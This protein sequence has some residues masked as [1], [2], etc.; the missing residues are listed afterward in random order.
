MNRHAIAIGLGLS[1]LHCNVANESV[2]AA[3]TEDSLLAERSAAESELG[4]EDCGC[5]GD[6]EDRVADVAVSTADRTA[7]EAADA[8]T[9]GPADAPVTVVAFMDYDCPYCVRVNATLSA[10]LAER[11]DVRVV[12]RQH[13]LPFHKRAHGAARA[14]LAAAELGRF[15]DFHQWL[16]ANRDAADFVGEAE[17]LGLDTRAFSAAVD[18]AAIEEQIASD[19]ELAKRLQARG[20]PTLFINGRRAVGALPQERLESLIDEAHPAGR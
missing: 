20:T 5:D 19:R 7:L 9:M 1:L 15:G 6:H 14:A 8:P 2:D 16:L 17:R 18:S 3:P 13:P 4:D 11:S 12:F 10:I